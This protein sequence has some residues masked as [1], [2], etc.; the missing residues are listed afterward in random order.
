MKKKQQELTK[1]IYA[2]IYT[3]Q[4]YNEYADE[5]QYLCKLT[6]GG[7]QRF[8]RS[9]IKAPEG[10]RSGPLVKQNVYHVIG[11]QHPTGV[12]VVS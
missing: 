4:L 6:S 5:W 3:E 1:S 11:Q 2:S 8:D 10:E 7:L 9:I 12:G